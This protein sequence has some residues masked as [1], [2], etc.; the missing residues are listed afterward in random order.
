LI[1]C[2]ITNGTVVTIHG[3]GFVGPHPSILLFPSICAPLVVQ[4]ATML[5]CTLLA[6]AAGSSTGDLSI[7]TNGGWSNVTG[8]N[9]T[10]APAPVLITTLSPLCTSDASNI[11]LTNCA[12][13][14]SRYLTL[15]GSNFIAV[16]S[17]SNIHV[18]PATLCGG[19][20]VNFDNT[21]L[22][23]LLQPAVAGSVVAFNV[24][25]NGGVSSSLSIT[26]G[27]QLCDVM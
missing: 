4:N 14:G 19:C 8:F 1:N 15:I 12:I 23:C 6:G 2:R 16:G 18:S 7:F 20:A 17:L 27:N 3:T 26:F 13:S 22:T 25:T 11:T 5:Y 24:S 9:I 21:I 10:F